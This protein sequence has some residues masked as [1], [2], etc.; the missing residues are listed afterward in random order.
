MHHF[1]T[2]SKGCQCLF[3]LT[4][5][6]IPLVVIT[7]CKK[8]KP[9]ELECSLVEQLGCVKIGQMDQKLKLVGAAQPQADPIQ[10]GN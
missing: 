5:L 7:G 3:H 2:L 4:I 10:R 8:I 6:C 1:K 9:I